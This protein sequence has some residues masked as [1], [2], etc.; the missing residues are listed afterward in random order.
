MSSLFQKIGLPRTPK[1]SAVIPSRN[2]PELVCR[3]VRSAL[4][5][6]FQDLE[7]IVVVD[8]P[9]AATMSALGQIEDGRLRVIQLDESV[10]GSE[11]RNIGARHARGEWIALLDDDDEWLPQKISKQLLAG[12]AAQGQLT[13]VVC[14]IILR[15]GG[16]ASIVP[17]RLP[18]PD[19]NM[20]EYL[21]GS[22]RNGFQTSA[23]FCSRQLFL[24]VPWTKLK[25]LQ[26]IDWFLRATSY[27]GAAFK[28]VDEPLCVYWTESEST[29]TN[30]L[31]WEV[32]F[33]W[34]LANQALMTKR[35]Y[36]C[37]IAKFCVHR[38]VRQNAGARTWWRLLSESIRQ[39]DP[40]ISSM[41]FFLS[42]SVVSHKTRRRIGNL[43]SVVRTR[44]SA[45][46]SLPDCK[47]VPFVA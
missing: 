17:N 20:S 28:V 4:Y 2:R 14:K 38:A 15:S 41:L 31:R 46:R 3:A 1:V 40:T 7:V 29:I 19:E 36:S 22:P 10:G 27:P 18:K 5:Q 32:C 8:G 24:A 25:G 47:G 23:F 33:N 45:K 39:G 44:Q 30:N 26:D 11:A 37:F 21:F 35:A 6:T 34:G 42:Y 16:Q 12:E 13:L 43:L 9:D